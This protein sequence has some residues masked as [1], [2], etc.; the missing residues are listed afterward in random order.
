MDP[1]VALPAG[2][3]KDLAEFAFEAFSRGVVL[4]KNAFFS[5]LEACFV[6]R[7]LQ[8]LGA[9]SFLT[10]KKKKLYFEQYIPVSLATLGKNLDQAQTLDLPGLLSLVKTIRL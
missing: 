8:I 5:C 10:R 9:Y 3:V 6:T 4:G 7:N 1:Y 2:L